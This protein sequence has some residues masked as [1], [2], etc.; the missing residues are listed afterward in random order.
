MKKRILSIVISLFLLLGLTAC[1][2]GG[3]TPSQKGFDTKAVTSVL[4]DGEIIAQN[5][6]Y[7]MEYA[8]DTGSVRLVELA[9]GT[10]W[11]VCPKS[12]GEVQYDDFGMPI[13]DHVFLQSAIEVG[14]MDVT[15]RGGGNSST[16]SMDAAVETGRVVVKKIENGVTIEYY[17]DGQKFMIPVDYVLKD[18]YL[19]ISVDSTKIQ[20]DELRVTY[21]SLAP[22]LNSVENDSENSYLFLPSGSGALMNVNSYNAQGLK[23]NAYVYGEDYIMEDKYIP[24]EHESLRMPVY[25]YKNGDK[26]G[27]AIIDNGAETARMNT[28]VGSTAYKFSTVYPSFYLRG[29]TN[30]QA[31]TFK[32]T[33]F[34]NVY[35]EN[36]IEGT[37]SL[38][39]YPLSGENADYNT[40]ADIYRDYLVNEKGLAKTGEEKA[41]NINLIGGAQITKSF[42]GVPYETVYAATT[43]N[44]ASSII[45]ELNE[46]IDSLS[47]KLKGFGA[48]GVDVGK[49]G[50]GFTVN[51]KFGSATNLKSLSSLCSEKGIDLYFDYDLVKFNSS[52]SGFSH[53]SDAVMN[54]GVLKAEQYI[55]DK[56]NR[57]N[58]TDE[59]YRFLRPIKFDDAVSKALKQNAKWNIS[60]VSLETLTSMAYSDYSEPKST[61]DFNSRHGF[62]AAVSEALK[63]VK[64]NNQKLMASDANDYAAIAAN[65]VTDVPVVSDRGYTFYEDVPFY[66]MVF[67]G[68]VPMTSESI[69]LAIDPQRIVLGA[70]E[71]GIG[72]N[73]TVINQ[74]GNEL[75]DSHYPYFFSTVY[76]GVKEDI[77]ATY[78]SLADYYDSINGA[79][80][81]SNTI[82]SSGVHCTAFDNGV[83]VYVNY[84][85]SAASTPAG[86]CAAQSYI[87]TGGAAQ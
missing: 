50:G 12:S 41:M 14:Y 47:V 5:S 61:V 28:V 49:I 71:S 17:F 40:M 51:D 4:A 2:E 13:Q 6:K 15:I 81:V 16:T 58:L 1:G 52:G 75:I 20:E 85:N 30:H 7:A 59:A 43:V 87:I 42:L 44:Q 84:N 27:F 67:K 33:Y 65:I 57:S 53:G 63:Q 36:M 62:V 55:T 66:S 9:S 21:V 11:D 19:S 73:Y 60:G 22:F 56:A 45:S 37:V 74:W 76:S 34:A 26:G 48:T 78:S 35:P 3:F 32:Q 54:S 29:Y 18:D 64:E 68:Y 70:V 24:S 31:R 86:E 77:L 8:A 38:R 79:K 83:T 25:G 39:F 80:I 10:K 72:L 23:Y 69:N 46:N 82:I